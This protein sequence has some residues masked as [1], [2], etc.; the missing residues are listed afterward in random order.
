MQAVHALGDKVQ[1]RLDTCIVNHQTCNRESRW[2]PP[3][4]IDLEPVNGSSLCLKVADVDND[5]LTLVS[6]YIA[7][8][9]C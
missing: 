4:I 2:L 8:S 7:F 5:V 3:R 1:K 9:H 6:R